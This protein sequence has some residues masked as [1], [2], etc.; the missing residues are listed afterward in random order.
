[1]PRQAESESDITDVLLEN[2]LLFEQLTELKGYERQY[3]NERNAVATLL[4]DQHGHLKDEPY[5]GIVHELLSQFNNKSDEFDKAISRAIE[6]E[7]EVITLKAKLN[8]VQQHARIEQMKLQEQ[9]QEFIDKAKN[10]KDRQNLS[11]NEQISILIQE[12]DS[13]VS[14]EQS[15]AE[16]VGEL[17]EE[18][19]RLNEEVTRAKQQKLDVTLDSESQNEELLLTKRELSKMRMDE[20]STIQTLQLELE[21]K[22]KRLAELQQEMV[23]L[24]QRTEVQRVELQ[25]GLDSQGTQQVELYQHK[26]K[27]KDLKDQLSAV[28]RQIETLKFDNDTLENDNQV[29]AAKFVNLSEEMSRKEES[30]GNV[31][32]DYTYKISDLE[33]TVELEIEKHKTTEKQLD[34]KSESFITLMSQLNSIRTQNNKALRAR[35]DIAAENEKLRAE[36]EE[37]RYDKQQLLHQA[38]SEDDTLQQ[39]LKKQTEQ[40]DAK[41]KDLRDRITELGEKILAL[42]EQVDN[43]EGEMSLLKHKLG[44]EEKNVVGSKGTLEGTQRKLL[45]TEKT[46]GDREKDI[47]ALKET[48]EELKSQ[49][50]EQVV[51]YETLDEELRL[52][53]EAVITVEVFNGNEMKL[54]HPTTT[55]LDNINKIRDY[56]LDN[57]QLISNYKRKS[58]ALHGEVKSIAEEYQ[59]IREKL[60]VADNETSQLSSQLTT[61]TT[62]LESSHKEIRTLRES[63]LKSEKAK[64]VIDRRIHA[65]E[66]A[67]QEMHGV[68]QQSTNTNDKSKL[69]TNELY[70]SLKGV[71]DD[72]VNNPT[73]VTSQ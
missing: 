29:L 39:L 14:N 43:K 42:E 27:V 56:T 1:M 47:M 67:L 66:Q 57:N 68:I 26:A 18:I 31:Q 30:L 59:Q 2:K 35:S 36:L 33:R 37:V 10:E 49:Q 6:K 60:Q 63:L 34:E 28:E 44:E 16:R 23:F 58:D 52:C 17:M 65:V 41:E 19:V 15:L 12:R 55:L 8:S 3:L 45:D 69:K 70:T 11:A 13:A 24:Q 71:I 48:I 4:Q 40:R 61:T 21:K 9:L 50:N 20:G 62:H 51:Q 46:V 73:P 54:L 53:R 38:T 64:R 7:G 72:L 5:Q 25:T 32:R 22:S